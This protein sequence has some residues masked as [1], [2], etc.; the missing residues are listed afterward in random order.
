[1]NT[2]LFI[3][4]RIVRSKSIGDSY[5]ESGLNQQNSGRS[6]FIGTQPIISI[7]TFSISLGIAI[8][9]IAIAIVTGFKSEIRSKVIGFGS[10]IQISN[11]DS[12]SSF[13]PTPIDKDQ[14]FYHYIDTINGIRH[15]QVF[16]TKAGIIKTKDAIQGIV[17]KG[18]GSDFDWK[19]FESKIVQGSAFKVVDS[20]KTND[21]I[22][23][24]YT[25]KKLK[26]NIDDDIIISFIQKTPRMRKFR[27]SG[28]YE[29]GLEE[30]DRLYV[31]G[32]IAHIQKLNDW[33]SNQIGGFEIL[34]DNYNDIDALGEYVY[35]NVIGADLFSQTVKETNSPIFDWLELQNVNTQ[36][37]LVLMVLVAGFNMISALLVLILERTR[38]IGILKAIGAGNWSIRKIFIYI[39]GGL[40]TKGLFWGNL[41][42][43]TCCI[44]QKQFGFIK[45]DQESYY[46]SVIPILLDI[47][48]ILYIN[49]GTL[50]I[51]LSMLIIPSIVVTRILPVNAIRF[52]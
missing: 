34:I 24:K 9:I 8:M 16:A 10:H 23:S 14:A 18:I 39:A 41:I 19:F 11:F 37:I 35:Y 32:D 47:P 51:C 40:I 45:L 43:I 46:V 48:T 30:L 2:E 20:V 44:L 42:G 6:Q 49:I 26:L 38:M 7:A 27:I 5:G 50:I 36:I 22:I 29:T 12:N 33:E 25:A 4:N 1:M 52:N 21:V 28:I 31:L 3:A 13:E 17:L 15:I